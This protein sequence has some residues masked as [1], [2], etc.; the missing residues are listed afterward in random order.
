V[1]KNGLWL[2]AHEA[3]RRAESEIVWRYRAALVLGSL[4]EDVVRVPLLVF[5]EYPSF[6]HFGGRGLPGGYLPFVW[7]GPRSSSDALYR[8]ALA[9][10]RAGRLAPAFVTI[11]RI[12]HVLTDVCIPSHV[13]RAAHDDDPFEWHVEGNVDRLR[14]LPV[15][16]IDPVRAPSELV[17]SLARE[18]AK[19]RPDRT[20]TP[21]GR[22]LRRAGLRRRVDAREARAQA[23]VLIPLAIGHATALLRMFER[24]ASLAARPPGVRA[25][26]GANDDDPGGSAPS[27]G[28]V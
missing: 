18:A 9:H 14:A 10:G 7:P 22:L 4:R 11:G 2:V 17:T 26:R 16:S 24:E 3:A 21:V 28:I 8:R 13:H 23:D 27:R 15:P 12:L 6:R 20:N 5:T 1:L 25:Q 19:H